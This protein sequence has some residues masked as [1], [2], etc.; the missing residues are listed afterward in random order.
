[1]SFFDE[2]DEPPTA[3]RR[4]R[5]SGTGRRP[6]GGGRRPPGNQQAI[7]RRRIVFVVAAVVLVILVVLGVH[8][9]QVSQTE[10]A[11]KDYNNNV[12]SVLQQSDQTGQQLFGELASGTGKTDP[13]GLQNRINETRVAADS[14]LERANGFDVPDQMKRA[15]QNLLLA[16]Q[17]RRDGIAGIASQIQPALAQPTNKDAIN[18]MGADTAHFYASDVVY[19]SYTA[20]L[21]VGAL[22]SAGIAVGGANGQTI[23]AG[24]FLPSI[25]WLSPTYIAREL[26]VT[27]STPGGK[28]AP[29]LHGHSLDSVSVNGNTLST[30]STNTIAGS[31]APTFT[32]HFTN[33]GTN[34]ETN[35]TLK[36]TVSGTSISG[37]TVVPQTTAGQST[38]GDVKLSSS[39]PAGTYTVT[40]TVEPVPGE[41]NTANN[42]LSFPV[43]FQ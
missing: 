42:S 27:T 6:S 11:L 10:S 2:V 15:Q 7:Q 20:P 17:M 26:H 21:I 14:Q 40:A 9:C 8:A 39:P 22:K 38:S 41:K 24:Q 34:T 30:T 35:V 31:P 16:L 12:S 25:S 28:P 19:K 33:G 29:G 37:Q 43:T 4:R 23:Y 13:T 36:V 3:P 5:P 32:L 1:L 18:A